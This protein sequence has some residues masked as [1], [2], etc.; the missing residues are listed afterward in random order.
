MNEANTAR[1]STRST[2]RPGV[3]VTG[4]ARGIGAAMAGR[5]AADGYLVVAIDRSEESLAETVARLPGEGHRALVG[6]VADEALLAAACELGA[7]APGGLTG[8]VANAGVARPG[9]SVDYA[10]SDW[11]ELLQVNLT[12]P[13]LGARTA[14]R[15]MESG[16]SMVLISSINGALGMGGR[17]AYCA[18]KAGVNGLV[19]SL[20]VEWGPDR[21]RVN[22]VAPGT[23]L[24][25]MA[26][27]FIATGY[28]TAESMAARVPMGHSGQPDDIAATVA[29][30]LS[31]DAKYITG[32]VVP[33]DGGWAING[34]ESERP[35]AAVATS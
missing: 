12:A 9:A 2:P 23:I 35:A 10:R 22:A 34:V 6:D 33:V 11:E 17:A 8:F 28:A 31:D 25:E 16:G 26:K 30:L 1:S 18:A 5:L 27:E 14:R 3:V 19:R 15:F 4:A 24:T 7:G 13:F 29:F 20:A 21:I 32:A